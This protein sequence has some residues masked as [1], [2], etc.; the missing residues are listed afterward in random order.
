M[1]WVKKEKE[2][3]MGGRERKEREERRGKAGKSTGRTAS[4]LLTKH[5]ILSFNSWSIQYKRG[6][7]LPAGD[8]KDS[9]IGTF[10]T[11]LDWFPA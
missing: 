1:V 7:G 11:A 10:R 4:P 3:K 8:E 5:Q 9:G 2:R 6:H